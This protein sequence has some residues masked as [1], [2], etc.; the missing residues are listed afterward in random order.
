MLLRK[1]RINVPA[2]YG[3]EVSREI[4]KYSF[5]WNHKSAKMVSML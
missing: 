5:K 4:N 3:A 2:I 1:I